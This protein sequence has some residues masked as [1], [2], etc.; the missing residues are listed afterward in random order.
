MP[1]SL[2]VEIFAPGTW[3][4]F[5]FSV[6]DMRGMV[7]AFKAL[8]DNIQVPL[9]FGHNDE[10]PMTDGQPALGW[11][12][13]V[14]LEEKG[15]DGKPKLMA[16]FID[17]PKVVIDAIKKRLFKNVSVELA[18]DATHKGKVYDYALTGV[19]LLGAD[20]P[21]V[22]TLADLQAFMSRD[23]NQGGLVF[24]RQM[25]FSALDYAESKPKSIGGTMP[26]PEELQAQLDEA[27][28]KIG[29]F[30]ADAA[31]RDATDKLRQE[32]DATAAIKLHRETLLGKFDTA[33]KGGKLLP[34]QR[35]AFTASL[36][37]N[38]DARV[39]SVTA[40]QVDAILGAQSA[41]FSR[42]PGSR[43]GEPDA[44]TADAGEQ[45]SDMAYELMAKDP[46]LQFTAALT[47]VMAG[48]KDLSKSHIQNE[49][50]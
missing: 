12:A 7:E 15:K 38:D 16:K 50:G 31:A 23:A 4:G 10:Q 11:V 46:K 19:A 2:N 1:K 9:K 18:F 25:A 49:E 5:P 21:A 22:N 39:M 28:A 26:T 44:S 36:G 47:R 40:E 14:W 27:N 6:A 35:E 48:N 8:K 41:S 29:K 3:N 42:E 34:A 30:T 45:L 24:S 20:L 43:Q 13:D 37:I 32:A 33:I 17:M